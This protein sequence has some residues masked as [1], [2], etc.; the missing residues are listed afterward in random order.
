MLLLRSLIFNILFFAWAG[1]AAIIFAPLFIVSTRTS[2]IAARPWAQGALWLAKTICG[3]THEVRG[4]QHIANTPVIYASKHQSAWDTA[5]F[6]VLLDKPTY[7]LKRELLSMP[8]WGWY[9]W[10]MQM[11]AID[12]S[13]GASSIKHMLKMA[14]GRLQENRSIIIYPEGTRTQP[15]ANP[16]YH[17]GTTALYSFLKTAV[18]PVALNSG[19]F[20]GK[21]A[22]VKR[23]GK[24]I[25]EFLPAIAPGLDKEVFATTLQ[26]T[27]ETASQ[28]LLE[29]A[30]MGAH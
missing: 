6:L 8:L 27:I 1:I 21:N 11:I 26:S 23:P 2:L 22:F 13:A 24:I 25:I 17:P 10:R 14:K 18:V 15:G 7:V 29:E 5:I 9:L 28:R 19:F 3:I 20:W 12:R 4:A 16:E 30:K